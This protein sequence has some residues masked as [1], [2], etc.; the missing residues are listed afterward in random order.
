MTSDDDVRRRRLRADLIN[1]RWGSGSD[2][3]MRRLARAF[4]SLADATGVD[5]WNLHQLMRWALTANL[6]RGATHAVRFVLQVWDP[7]LDWRSEAVRAGLCTPAEARRADHPLSSFNFA[8][9]FAVW[10]GGDRDAVVAWCELPFRVGDPATG[11]RI[12]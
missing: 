2:E 6:P 8:D 9:A 3:R 5:P 12:R 10:D 1:Q 11:R 4:P 7:D